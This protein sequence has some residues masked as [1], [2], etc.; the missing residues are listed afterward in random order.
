MEPPIQNNIDIKDGICQLLSVIDCLFCHSNRDS[1]NIYCISGLGGDHR[2][3][4]HIQAPEGYEIVPVKWIAPKPKESLVDY[5]MRLGACIDRSQPFILVGLSLGGIMAVELAKRLSPVC[6]IIISSIPV[7][8]E[9]PGYYKT[10]SKLKLV[11][12]VPSFVFKAAAIL[13]RLYSGESRE[14][15][16]LVLRMIREGDNRFIKW[17]MRAVTEWKNEIV[18]SPLWHIHGT[19]DEV[20]PIFRTHPTH[21]IRKGRHLLL[22]S[23]SPEINRILKEIIFNL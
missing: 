1:M 4:K 5:A 15:K 20:F 22:M 14:D 17:A 11:R 18:P 3:F 6:T 21:I 2:L 23:H 19:K 8:T 13:K 10:A 12:I 16:R 7:S 9:L